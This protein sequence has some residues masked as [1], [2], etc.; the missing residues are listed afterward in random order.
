MIRSA[1]EQ[2]NLTSVLQCHTRLCIVWPTGSYHQMYKKFK[3]YIPNKL[4]VLNLALFF[5]PSFS[6]IYQ[7]VLFSVFFSFLIKQNPIIYGVSLSFVINFERYKNSN[8]FSCSTWIDIVQDAVA[9]L[10][11]FLFTAVCKPP[12]DERNVNRAI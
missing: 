4:K 3:L 8:K 5:L 10:C 11:L 7:L 9:G 12:L 2:H 6:G 1:A